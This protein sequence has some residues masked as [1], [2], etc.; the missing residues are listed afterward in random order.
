MKRLYFSILIILGVVVT[1]PCLYAQKADSLILVLER[2]D[3]L[4]NAGNFEQALTDYDMVEVHYALRDPLMKTLAILS[5]GLCYYGLGEADTA[6]HVLME[7]VERYATL[8]QERPKIKEALPISPYYRT[9]GMINIANKKYIKANGFLRKAMEE[10]IG[11]YGDS[12]PEVASS[13]YDL[14]LLHLTLGKSVS[15]NAYLQEALNIYQA[16]GEEYAG[17]VVQIKELLHQAEDIQ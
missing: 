1:A 4:Y 2:A 11:K 16:S 8:A 12:H 9:L 5:G 15:A 6:E 13:L 3:S 7:G 17:K 14:A 10:N